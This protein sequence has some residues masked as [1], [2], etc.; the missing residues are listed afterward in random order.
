[1]TCEGVCKIHDFSVTFPVAHDKAQAESTF[2]RI[3]FWTINFR[4]KSAEFMF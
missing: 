3:F 4:T 2:S 1:M